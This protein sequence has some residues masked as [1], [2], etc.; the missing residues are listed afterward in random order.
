MSLPLLDKGADLK[1]N[2]CV[3]IYAFWSLGCG[4]GRGG[5]EALASTDALTL[6]PHTREPGF[7]DI[8]LCI[9]AKAALSGCKQGYLSKGACRLPLG[10]FL[11]TLGKYRQT[12]SILAQATHQHFLDTLPGTNIYNRKGLDL[13]IVSPLKRGN[14]QPYKS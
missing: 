5:R 10:F 3:T 8:R 1:R 12:V 4:V 11:A 2:D 9:A 6:C 13:G 7:D 14:I